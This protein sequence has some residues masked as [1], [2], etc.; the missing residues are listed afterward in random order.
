MFHFDQ[1]NNDRICHIQMSEFFHEWISHPKNF[2]NKKIGN[3][4]KTKPLSVISVLKVDTF[5]ERGP[6]FFNFQLFLTKFLSGK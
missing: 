1:V 5:I 2:E 6:S 4:K 3:Q